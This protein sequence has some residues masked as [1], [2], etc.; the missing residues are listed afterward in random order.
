MVFPLPPIIR[1]GI[2]GGIGGIGGGIGGRGIGGNLGVGIRL[3]LGR[4][5][6]AEPP[7]RRNSETRAKDDEADKTDDQRHGPARQTCWR[8]MDHLFMDIRFLGLRPSE[9]VPVFTLTPTY[10]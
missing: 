7:A 8:E 9:F 4:W 10:P 2:G 5:G 3:G 6:A 1:G